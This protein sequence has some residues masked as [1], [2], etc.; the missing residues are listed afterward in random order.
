M[1]LI[2]TKG[3][4]GHFIIIIIKKK[5]ERSFLLLDSS[6]SLTIFFLLPL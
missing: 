4:F 2:G 3:H 5:E 1:N 6:P